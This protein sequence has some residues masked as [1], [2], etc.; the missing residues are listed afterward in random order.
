M[1]IKKSKE[2]GEKIYN[3]TIRVIILF[4]FILFFPTLEI[5]AEKKEETKE[6]N[7]R[8]LSFFKRSKGHVKIT[9]FAYGIKNEKGEYVNETHSLAFISSHDK[10]TFSLFLL[11]D[12]EK[13]NNPKVN[14]NTETFK[15]IS[16]KTV[17]IITRKGGEVTNVR[18]LYYKEKAN[19]KFRDYHIDFYNYY[20]FANAVEVLLSPGTTLNAEN[21][22]IQLIDMFSFFGYKLLIKEKMEE[23]D[24]AFYSSTGK[25][26]IFKSVK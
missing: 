21:K 3:M 10:I 12:K 22:E 20:M 6:L 15:K 18:H 14:V 16:D 8:L 7:K 11:N 25:E 26:F 17:Q 19:K 2:C 13:L 4:S 23:K 1:K 5:N 24:D 9:D